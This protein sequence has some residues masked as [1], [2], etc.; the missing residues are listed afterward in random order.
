MKIINDNR[1]WGSF[2][3]F[4]HNEISTVKIISVEAGHQLSL[5]YHHKRSEFWVILSGH[6]R[7]TVGEKVKIAQEG[8]EFFISPKTIHRIEAPE[9]NSQILE[10]SFGDFDEND[11]VRIE[12]AYGRVS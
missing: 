10:I 3:Q 1:P 5:Q 6:P 11:I 7:I 8:E 12:D 9:D 4:T 2:R